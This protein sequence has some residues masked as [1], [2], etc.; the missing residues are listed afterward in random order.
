MIN[1]LPVYIYIKKRKEKPKKCIK[2][3]KLKIDVM[4]QVKKN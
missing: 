1:F 3:M 4:A 2:K